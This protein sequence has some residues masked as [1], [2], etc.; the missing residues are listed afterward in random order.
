[1]TEPAATEP[2]LPANQIN[3]TLFR[4]ILLVPFALGPAPSA[5]A[6]AKNGRELMQA[7][8][9]ALRRANGPW[10]KVP[11][12]VRHLREDREELPADPAARARRLAPAYEELVYFE[13]YVQ[14]FLYGNA[15]TSG[16]AGEPGAGR[17][18]DPIAIFARDDLIGLEVDFPF[19]RKAR[20]GRDRQF[21][22][23][24]ERCNL[25]LCETGNAL[26]VL[27]VRR[28]KASAS[29]AP[30][31]GAERLTLA[32]AQLL[33]E[34]LRRVFPPYFSAKDRRLGDPE[35]ELEAPYFPRRFCWQ[36][37]DRAQKA[38]YPDAAQAIA[39][40]FGSADTAVPSHRTPPL[41]EPWR[42]LLEPLMVAGDPLAAL[43]GGVLLYQTGDD[44]AFLMAQVGVE[45]AGAI[46][47]A[48]WVRLCFADAP[49]TGWPYSRCFLRDFERQ[50][51]Y[52]RFFEHD[53]KSWMKTR[54]LVC[55]YAFVL[56]GSAKPDAVDDFFSHLLGK[57]FR[58]HYFQLVLI[59][60]LQKTALLTLSERLA[61]ALDLWRSEQPGQEP[62]P[63]HAQIGLLQQ[64]ALRFTH[65]YWFEDI[66]AQLQAQELFELL[67]RHLRTRALHDQLSAEVRATSG[68]LDLLKQRELAERQHDL[69]TS[70]ARLNRVAAL[71]LVLATVTG[72]F[73]MNILIDDK[74][75]VGASLLVLL[76]GLAVGLG[77]FTWFSRQ[78]EDLFQ[79][80]VK[81]YYWIKARLKAES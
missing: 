45:D 2:G 40:V 1:M 44:R 74:L 72:F 52:D 54:Y 7:A 34:S 53:P 81:A 39:E 69:A 59:S 13:P 61:E 36:F 16:T 30:A 17:D 24:V 65:R 35:A 37:R 71:G 22:L 62:A 43:A 47:K 50:H 3:L 58:R 31:P 25:Y 75:E 79:L 51:C 15:R 32:D 12:P 18:D 60:L 46:R 27:E 68:W 73:G 23:E 76:A 77:I 20:A 42:Q 63:F 66:S 9:V 70:A 78:E 56:V 57:H 64:E 41:F 26:L 11:D 28:A 10:Q 14:R 33:M 67:R 49:G 5:T 8:C 80:I 19:E 4:Q 6:D 55:G 48:D 29:V 21:D 38:E